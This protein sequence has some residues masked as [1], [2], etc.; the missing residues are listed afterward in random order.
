MLQHARQLPERVWAIEDFFRGDDQVQLP[1]C[2]P[3]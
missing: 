1:H 2:R 3:W